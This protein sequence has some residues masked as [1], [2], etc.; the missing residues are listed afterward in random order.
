MIVLMKFEIYQ[1]LF[2]HFIQSLSNQILLEVN[3][4]AINEFAWFIIDHHIITKIIFDV[5]FV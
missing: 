2:S 3:D 5:H 1:I 4:T